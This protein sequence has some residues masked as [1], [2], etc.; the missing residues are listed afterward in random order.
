[1]IG[2]LP[3]LE[4]TDGIATVSA[5]RSVFSEAVRSLRTSID[6]LGIDE[7][8]RLLV[9]TSPSPGDGKSTVSSNLSAV[10]AQAGY[11]TLLV[12]ADLRKPRLYQV[13]GYD[14]DRKGLSDLIAQVEPHRRLAARA[15]GPGSQPVSEHEV[16]K[17]VALVSAIAD[18]MDVKT[19]VD[20][21]VAELKQDVTPE[22]VLKEIEEQT[23]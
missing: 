16:T 20:S 23:S 4:G 21:E 19:E 1:M 2:E 8:I 10:Y 7:P 17:L 3:F 13:F 11:R 22:V 14:R 6:F 12:S 5:S 15:A 9:V 18:R